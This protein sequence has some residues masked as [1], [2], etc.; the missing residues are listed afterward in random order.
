MLLYVTGGV[1]AAAGALSA[2]F[3]LLRS[4]AGSRGPGGGPLST[5]AGRYRREHGAGG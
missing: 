2:T 4:P 5:P 1:V 3:W